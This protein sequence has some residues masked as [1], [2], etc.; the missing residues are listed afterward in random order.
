V[1]PTVEVPIPLL[2]VTD[3]TPKVALTTTVTVGDPPSASQYA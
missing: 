2:K 1:E 3:V